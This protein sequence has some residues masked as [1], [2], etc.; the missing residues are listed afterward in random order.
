MSITGKIKTFFADKEKTEAIFPRTKVSAISDDNGRGL[1]A[2]L[3][4]CATEAFVTNKIAEAQLSGGGDIDLSGYATKDELN[5]ITPEDIGAATSGHTHSNYVPTSRT[6][7]GKALSSNISLS[8]SDVGA[9]ASSHNHSASN[10]TSGTLPISRGGTGATDAGNALRALCRNDAT[11]SSP[12]HVL[13]LASNSWANTGQSSVAQLRTAMGI[14]G[15]M[16]WARVS[17][18]S[19][20]GWGRVACESAKQWAPTFAQRADVDETG[21]GGY[22]TWVATSICKIAGYVDFGWNTT[23][24]NSYPVNLWWSK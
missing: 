24:T 15:G 21:Y 2:I 7:N 19:P 14:P 18:S 17:Q 8:A 9:A 16:G 13:T 1:D 23:V 5:A 10:I 12:T 11:N 6:V 4:D 20:N 3:D 22:A